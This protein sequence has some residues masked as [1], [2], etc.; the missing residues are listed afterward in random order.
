M[1]RVNVV[2]AA[3]AGNV[4]KVLVQDGDTVEAGQTILVLEAMKMETDISAPRAGT[5]ASVHVAEGDAVDVGDTLI[6][7]V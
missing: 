1:S 6:S 4:F 3:L 5:I 2:S 7:L